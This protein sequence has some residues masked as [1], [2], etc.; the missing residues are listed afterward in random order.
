M[1]HVAYA[2]VGD[3]YDTKDPVKQVAQR[4]AQQTSIH[5][6][7]HGYAEVSDT[8][9]ES[10]FVWKQ[11]RLWMASVIEGLGTKSLVADAMRS[12]TH[13]TYYDTIA[14]DTVATIIND[15]TSVG[16]IPLVIHAYWAMEHNRWLNDKERI[17][18]LIAGWKNACDIARI[19]WGGGET[20]TL[21]GIMAHGTVDVAGSA[22]GVIPTKKR[23]LTDR[24]LQA[25]DR[26]I[27]L[28]SSGIN[29][30][31]VSLARDVAKRLPKGY[32]TKLP[33]GRMYGEAL[34]TKTHIYAPLLEGLYRADIRIH[35]ISNITGHGLRK[36][37]RGRPDF[38]YVIEQI[39][40]P[41]EEFLCIQ[42]Y[43]RQTDAQMYGTY[44]MGMDYALFVPEKDVKKLQRVVKTFGFS[45]I[46]AGYVA[47]GKRQ[48]VIK[49]KNITFSSD[50]LSLR[51]R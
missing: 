12:I 28:Q 13:K 34:L 26:I 18:D 9:G 48:V 49:P 46:D 29:A 7:A 41:P 30:N 38:S 43:A 32:A 23:L 2:A 40:D 35:Y 3:N 1:K 22:I 44:N 42:T 17:N 21:Q 37:M 8:R 27:L 15:L 47:K 33:S 11:G 6:Q 25:G 20:P 5:L 39:A 24:A 45:S 4:A 14:H 10:A 51:A 31:G 19:T 50:T 16:A 36:I